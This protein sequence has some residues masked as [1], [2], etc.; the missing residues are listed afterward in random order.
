MGTGSIIGMVCFMMC[1]GAGCRQRPSESDRLARSQGLARRLL[2]CVNE[3]V[4][5]GERELLMEALRA[6]GS[7]RPNGSNQALLAFLNNR[8]LINDMA[9]CD[10]GDIGSV[11]GSGRLEFLDEW[12]RPLVVATSEMREVLICLGGEPIRVSVPIVKDHEILIW[13]VGPNGTSDSGTGDDLGSWR[14]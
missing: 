6:V 13:S 8:G 14:E 3:E 4:A 12:G 9:L 5:G 11:A 7:G 10:F 1:L 2:Q